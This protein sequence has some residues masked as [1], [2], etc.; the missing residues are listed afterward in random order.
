MVV[1]AEG[2]LLALGF[3]PAGLADFVLVQY[4]WQML[5]YP[6]D[7]IGHGNAESPS[8]TTQGAG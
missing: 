8:D 3:I 7:G 6:F 4:E 2:T 5:E 1:S